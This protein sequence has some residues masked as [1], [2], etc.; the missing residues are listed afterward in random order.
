MNRTSHL[1]VCLIAGFCFASTS[2][3]AQEG[4]DDELTSGITQPSPAAYVYVSDSHKVY[5]F[6]A[7]TSGKLKPITGSPFEANGVQFMAVNGKYL[8][9]G[10]TD[11]SGPTVETFTI[12]TNGALKLVKTYLAANSAPGYPGGPFEG[13]L[14]VDHSGLVLYLNLFDGSNFVYRSLGVNHSTGKL[15]EVGDELV[16]SIEEQTNWLAFLSNNKFAYSY[17]G[18]C[19][20]PGE[21]LG[22]ERKSDGALTSI[23]LP[24]TIPA[25]PNNSTYYCPLFIAAD[26]TNHLAV[27]LW[28]ANAEELVGNPVLATF[29]AGADG[30]LTTTSTYENMLQLNTPGWDGIIPWMRMSPS[31]KLLAVGGTGGLQ[32]LKFNGADPITPYRTLLKSASTFPTQMYWDNSNHLYVIGNDDSTFTTG[33]LWVYTITPTSV[34][35]APGSPY[36][37][38]GAATLIVQ[39]K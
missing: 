31:G 3:L 32:I 15:T 19:N 28:E 25:T 24:N 21:L 16:S 17:L 8:F 7:A 35:E 26:P 38:P 6:S 13:P 22:F 29:T 36:S 1:I 20:Q 11:A 12:G 37:I 18:D 9:G 27:L 33:K 30:E 5:S 39:P 23:S 10:S 14:E 4:Q 34:S 2:A